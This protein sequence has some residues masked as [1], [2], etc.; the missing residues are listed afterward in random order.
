MLTTILVPLG[1]CLVSTAGAFALVFS[2]NA[3]LER[4]ELP[5]WVTR[6]RGSLIAVILRL[7][8]HFGLVIHS[9]AKEIFYELSSKL[10]IRIMPFLINLIGKM[11][12]KMVSWVNYL[13]GKRQLN[14]GSSPSWF[15]RDIKEHS[16]S[17][18]NHTDRPTG[19]S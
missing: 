11:E 1:L 15:I 16:D 13:N 14:R 7:A 6:P 3:A 5:T 17:A 18:K 12:T 2:R 19:L 8:E 4:G 9:A 10:L